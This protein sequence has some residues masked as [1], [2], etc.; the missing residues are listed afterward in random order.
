MEDAEILSELEQWLEKRCT[1]SSTVASWRTGLS[2]RGTQIWWAVNL[3]VLVTLRLLKNG[4]TN[5]TDEEFM[6]AVQDLAAKCTSE[7]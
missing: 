5:Q 4:Q 2:C 1:M 6:A 3:E 7:P